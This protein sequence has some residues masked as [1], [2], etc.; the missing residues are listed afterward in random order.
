MPVCM[1]RARCLCVWGGSGW[2]YEARRVTQQ[3]RAWPGPGPAC[4]AKGVLVWAQSSVPGS[5]GGGG[6]VG[7]T[8][9][10]PTLAQRGVDSAFRQSFT[11][12]LQQ[13]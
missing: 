5:A 12:L 7:P 11:E 6:G 4:L 13:A 3:R 1:G 9:A 2:G 8:F 10:C